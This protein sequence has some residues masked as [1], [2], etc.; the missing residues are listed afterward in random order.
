[1]NLSQFVS[2]DK[3]SCMRFFYYEK[4]GIPESRGFKEDLS[5]HIIN[6]KK[7]LYFYTFLNRGSGAFT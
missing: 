6:N 7:N 1:M 4:G 3:I 5:Y 2:F